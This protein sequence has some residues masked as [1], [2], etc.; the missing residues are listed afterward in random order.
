PQ[1]EPRGE[2]SGPTTGIGTADRIIP[3]TGMGPF[4]AKAVSYGEKYGL[5]APLVLKTLQIESGMGTNMGSLGN[6]Y[7]LNPAN[8]RTMGGGDMRDV[9]RQLD[10][11]AKYLAQQRD[12]AR[13]RLGHEPQDWET[14]MVH[15]QGPAGGPAL[16][17]A[18]PDAN[19]VNVLAPFYRDRATAMKAVTGN[20]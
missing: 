5:P 8:W 20:G 6:D 7:Q 12:I 1:T 14:Y 11:G 9:D 4:A 19:V 10:Y 15:Q 2:V 18:P 17:L 16:M 3:S 13:N